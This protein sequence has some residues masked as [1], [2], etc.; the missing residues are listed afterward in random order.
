MA[1]N[2]GIIA[3]TV[4][5]YLAATSAT[6]VTGG[7]NTAYVDGPMR[8]TGN[9]SFTFPVGNGNVYAP[10]GIGVSGIATDSYTGQYFR[11]SAKNIST[12]ISGITQFS[13]CEYW[14]M[15]RNAG[16][17]VPS[18]TMSW[19]ASS[20]CGGVGY[21]SDLPTLRAAQYLAPN[22]TNAG[23]TGSGSTA[24]G[25]IA[26]TTNTSAFGFF[27]IASSSIQFNPLPLHFAS[28]KARLVQSS[29]QVDWMVTGE[30]NVDHYDLERSFD[31]QNFRSLILL[32]ATNRGDNYYSYS[33]LSPLP[34]INYYRVKAFDRDGSYTISPVMV[35]RTVQD[36][37]LLKVFPTITQGLVTLQHEANAGGA[38][39]FLRTMEGK[40][41]RQI[42]PGKEAEQIMLNLSSFPTGIYLLQYLDTEGKIHLQKIIR[43]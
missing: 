35:I 9:T 37:Q 39:I 11:S 10:L 16:A 14:S 4:S 30:L 25:T 32:G 3:A 42:I 19:G 23:G 8:K 6:T 41:L 22:W 33:D 7:S 29:I 27:T 24:S 1:L 17:S 40:M 2:S 13:N 31:G 38:R 43:Q 34:N 18:I 12:A 26:S 36:V 21:V 5:N 28:A 20:N 15:T